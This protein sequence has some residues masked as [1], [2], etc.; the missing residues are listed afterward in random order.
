MSTIVL[1]HS[2]LGLRP[3]VLDLA[4]AL[5]ADGHTVITPDLFGGKVF[6]RLEDGVAERD[7]IG[8]PG[9]M[10]RA[11]E[12]VAGLPDD[13]VYMGLS[14]GAASAEWLAATR[15]GAR[16]AV[17]LHAALPVQ[18]FGVDAWPDVPVQ[19]HYAERDPWVDPAVPAALCDSAPERVEVYGYPGDG[20]LFTDADAPEHDAASAALVVQ[21]VR[22][23][24]SSDA[25]C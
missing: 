19:I 25:V 22:A 21:R 1:F 15:P 8:I 14:M 9:L 24:L 23:F 7:A 4:A 3:A 2:A 5:R 18:A 10:Q 20:H 16:G 12:A 13:L 6:D 17:L 11:A